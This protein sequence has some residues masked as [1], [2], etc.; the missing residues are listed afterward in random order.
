MSERERA[1]KIMGNAFNIREFHDVV[2]RAGSRPLPKVRGDI[3]AWA[4]SAK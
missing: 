3:R 4:G 2:L 1:R